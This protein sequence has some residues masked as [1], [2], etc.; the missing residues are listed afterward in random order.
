MYLSIN[1]VQKLQT[2]EIIKSSAIMFWSNKMFYF[3]HK[4]FKKKNEM[5]KINRRFWH[6]NVCILGIQQ[7]STSL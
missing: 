5:R 3:S 7:K 4:I 1:S 2:Y 6:V